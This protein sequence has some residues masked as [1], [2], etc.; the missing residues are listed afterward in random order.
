[1]VSDKVIL[2]GQVS[3]TELD[4]AGFTEE[5]LAYL[6]LTPTEAMEIVTNLGGNTLFG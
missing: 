4:K 5:V 1:M 3:V 6:G 2:D